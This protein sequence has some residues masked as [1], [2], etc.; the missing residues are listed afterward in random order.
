MNALL[1]L[2]AGN[3]SAEA[4]QPLLS[5]QPR[6]GGKSSLSLAVERARAFP[7]VSRAAILAGPGFDGAD[8]NAEIVRRDEPWTVKALLE[9]VAERARGF[10]LCYFAW[11]DCP[12]LDPALA[13]R[14]AQR[15]LRYGAEYS[16]CDG[17]PYGLGPEILLPSA[18]AILAG[19]LGDADGGPVGRDAI[20]STIQKDINA[21]DI[22]TE[23]SSVDLRGHRLALCADS[24]RN[25]LLLRRFAQEA[26]AQGA[27]GVPDAAF[28][29]RAIAER[30]VSLRGLPAFYP[31]Q[32][33]GGCPQA[34]IYCPWPKAGDSGGKPNTER[35]DFMEARRFEE[36]LDKIIDFSG[37]AVVGFSLWG[38]VALHPQKVELFRAALS[39][40]EISLVVETSGIGWRAEELEEI[41]RIAAAAPKRRAA[42]PSALSWIVSLD[43]ANPDLYKELRGAGFA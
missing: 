26:I 5:G 35:R 6:L 15:H 11:A 10:D 41:A 33:F 16:Y 42:F 3:L 31:V 34:C 1:V 27:A 4:S 14:L 28:V 24:K 20:F 7:G 8:L 17:W 25:L 30:R 22:E 9:A 23:I 38:E 2:Y 13:D 29:E 12:F 18:A 39:R 32:V 43:S 40:P 19:L 21:F 36:L 37:D